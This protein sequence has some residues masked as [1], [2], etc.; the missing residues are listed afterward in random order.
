MSVNTVGPAPVE[1]MTSGVVPNLATYFDRRD[2]LINKHAEEKTRV[3]TVT[4]V[5][6]GNWHVEWPDLAQTPEVPSVANLIEM[7]IGHW[8]SI[9]GA[10]L[11]SIRVPVNASENRTQAKRGARKRERR[12]REIFDQ[13]NISMQAALFWGD[14]AGTGMAIGGVWANFEEP[15]PAKRNPYIVRYDP[16]HTYVVKDNIGDVVEMLVARKIDRGELLA[17]FRGTKYEK[18]FDKARE[19][20]LEEWFWYDKKQFMHAVVDNSTEGRKA[21]RYV[22]LAQ[23][24]NKLG[25]VPAREVTRPTFDGQRRGVFDQTIHLLRTMHRLMVMTIWSTEEN[26]FPAVATYDVANPQDFGPGAILQ[27]RSAESR[28]ERVGPSSHFD[29]KDLIARI[30]EDAARNAVY[31]QQL[32]GDPGASI[33]SARGI[34]ASMGALDARLAVAHKGFEDFFGSLAGMVLAFDET[35]CNGEKTIMGDGRDMNPA[36]SFLPERDINGAWKALATYGIGAGSDP[37]NI[38]VR[39]QMHQ[40]SGLL[41]RETARQHL[42]YLE[43]PD[44]EPV[45]LMR[46]AMSDAIIA[47]VLAMAQQGDPSIAAKAYELLDKD[48]LDFDSVMSELIKIVAPDQP[49][50]TGGEGALGALQGAE[51]LARGGIPGNAAQAPAPQSLPPLGQ[52]LG[53]DAR[54]VS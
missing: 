28:V 38:E 37:N 24:E 53:Q 34:Q 13:S 16:R 32:S 18:Y 6:N 29:V 35:Y 42:P 15:N 2:W 33:T 39:L 9:G 20:D 52:L 40:A 23:E 30:G 26:A 54:M 5:A 10:V 7:G 22:V 3:Q 50:Q 48:D 45:H 19:N 43:D 51:S 47:G 44:A 21:R 4:N 14:Y 25:F 36:E 49:Q 46:E 17:M 12:I 27:L 31:P 1:S 41:S 11:P 8:A